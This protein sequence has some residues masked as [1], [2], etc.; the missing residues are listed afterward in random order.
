MW[1]DCQTMELSSISVYTRPA[2]GNFD[3]A[4]SSLFVGKKSEWVSCEYRCA[5]VQM[6]IEM[7]WSYIFEA[8][9]LDRMPTSGVQ[10]SNSHGAQPLIDAGKYALAIYC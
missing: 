3:C 1:G 7:Y 6:C 10:K 9:P 2:S 4:Q 8:H 5:D